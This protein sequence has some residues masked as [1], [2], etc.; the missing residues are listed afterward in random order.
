MACQPIGSSS[1][2]FVYLLTNVHLGDPV[3]PGCL[4][5]SQPMSTWE[6]Q[7][8][9]AVCISPNQ[10][11]PGRSSG[12]WLFVYLPTNGPLGDPV[13]PGCLYISQPMAPWEIQWLLA[14]CISP[15]QWPPGRSSGSWLFV[16]L[17]TNG[18]LGDP[19]A[20]GCLYIS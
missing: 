12:S 18:P 16:Y 5:I 2:L 3:A 10:W 11:P 9:L 6:I 13:A 19:V 8:L 1:W 4:Y 20:P 14:V 17:P 15:N 7:W